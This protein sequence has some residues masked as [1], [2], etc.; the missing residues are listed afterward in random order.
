MRPHELEIERQQLNGSS[1]P[2]RVVRVQS[3]GP[4]VR[5]ELTSDRNEPITVELTHDRY[6]VLGIRPGENVF[7]QVKDARVFVA[8]EIPEDY[9]I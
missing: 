2:S 1:V 6:R 4:V 5:V 8:D 3:A 7:V 9:S